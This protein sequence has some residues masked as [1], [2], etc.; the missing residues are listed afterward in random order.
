MKKIHDLMEK[1]TDYQTLYQAYLYSRM[2]KRYKEEV[3]IFS[4]NLERELFKLQR[5]L[6][7]GTYRVGPYREFYVRIPKKRLIMALRF[8]DRIVQWAIY[9]VFNPYL[10]RRFIHDSYGCRVGKGALAAANRLQYWMRQVNRKPIHAGRRWYYLKL[11]IS[12]YFYRVDHEIIMK[13]FSWM[14]DDAE[15]LTLMS[16]II[17]GNAPFGLPPGATISDCPPAMRLYDVGMPI[18]NLSSQMVANMYLDYL[19]QFCKHTLKIHYY[20]RYMDDVVILHNDL[21]EIHRIRD[22]IGSF[23][24]SNLRLQLNDKTAIRPIVHGIEFVGW[25]IY[26]THRKLRKCSIK[27]MKRSLKRVARLYADGEVD[28]DYCLSVLNSYFGILSHS[29]DYAM[30]KWI[31]DNTVLQRKEISHDETPCEGQAG[32]AFDRA[33]QTEL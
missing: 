29:D 4:A 31:A 27:H 12:K 2:N 30:R 15:F 7:D 26:A 22:E 16:R 19:D 33:T 10:E 1:V 24:Q 3:L 32:G 21:R 18:G 23:V 8:R 6:R 25:R 9:L 13:M 14:T 17:S 5:E 20:I 11:D 28:I